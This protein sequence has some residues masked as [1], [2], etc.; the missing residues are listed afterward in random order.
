MPCGESTT[1][2]VRAESRGEVRKE[3]E[4]QWEESG[5]GFT[6]VFLT[7]VERGK[8]RREGVSE[9]KWWFGRAR[10]W[11]KHSGDGG[12]RTQHRGT[13]LDGL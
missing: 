4:E 12:A 13:V 2:S 1:R 3:E 8:E 10:T 6:L 11:E 5:E 9:V 7:R